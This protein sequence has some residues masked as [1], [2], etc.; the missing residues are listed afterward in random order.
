MTVATPSLLDLITKQTKEQVFDKFISGIKAQGVDVSAWQPGEPVR[1]AFVVISDFVSN[2]WNNFAVPA[3]RGGFLDYAEGLWLSIKA[4]SDYSVERR[5]QTRGTGTI[6][7]KNTSG[8]SYSIG[9]GDITIVNENTGKTHTNTSGGF[10][11]SN[12]SL[13]PHIVLKF[14]ADEAGEASN[15]LPS[16]LAA[17]PSTAPAGVLVDF[18]YSGNTAIVGQ[19][20]E[21][22]PQLRERSRLSSAINPVYYEDGTKKEYSFGGPMS[23]YEYVALSSVRSDGTP[24]SVNRVRVVTGGTNLVS[25]YLAGPSGTTPGDM[26]TEDTDVFS[27]YERMLSRINTVGTTLAVWGAGQTNCAINMF[28]N[29]DRDSNI[30]KEEAEAA[31]TKEVVDYIAEMRIGGDHATPPLNDTESGKLILPML[32]SVA[33]VAITKLRGNTHDLVS[34]TVQVNAGVADITIPYNYVPV[35]TGLSVIATLVVQS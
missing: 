8:S 15:T 17:T 3:I 31:V 4:S 7:V 14:Q 10:L 28:I 5:T 19:D 22:D 18:S 9:A 6:R 12:A 11:P 21:T 23:A 26:V 35:I 29:I 16:D 24:V 34:T 1:G 13:F 27:V 20:E 25:V 32:T 2:L 30:T 33:Q